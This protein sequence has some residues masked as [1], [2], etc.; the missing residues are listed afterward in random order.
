MT[1]SVFLVAG[2]TGRLGEATVRLLAERGDKLLITG[3]NKDRLAELAKSHGTPGSLETLAVDITEPGGAQFAAAEA[4]RQFGS[5]TGLVHLVGQF[6]V[7]PLMLTDVSTYAEVLKSNFLSAVVATQAVLPHLTEGGRLV[8]FG[9][10]LADEPL[11]ALSAYAAS[12]AALISWMRS[13]A[14]E[15]KR[16]GIHAN[17]V[18]LTLVDTPEMREERPGLDLDHTVSAELVARAVGFLTSAESDGMYGS[19]VPVLGRFGFSSV[20]AG[21]PPPGVGGRP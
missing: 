13:V 5:L 8:Y 15:V 20:L 18:S 4:V 2:A 17:A 7:G 11:A 10:P 6:S 16:R 1:G 12:K 19:V 9:S 21:G 3:R 14:H